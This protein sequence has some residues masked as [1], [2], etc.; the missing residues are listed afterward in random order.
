MGR[1]TPGHNLF[2]CRSGLPPLHGTG[3]HPGEAPCPSA[4]P[5]KPT[6]PAAHR[7]NRLRG[8][9]QHTAGYLILPPRQDGTT[10]PVHPGVCP[11]DRGSRIHRKGGTACTLGTEDGTARGETLLDPLRR[12]RDPHQRRR[13][14][15]DHQKG[16][17][18]IQPA[19]RPLRQ[20]DDPD[21]GR[22]H[23]RVGECRVTADL[24]PR[25][26]TATAAKSTPRAKST[27]R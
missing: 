3:R 6:A 15:T 18:R 4:P 7:R 10:D 8:C 26:S 13:S 14:R 16:G 27:S 23:P 12:L 24:P 19:A 1:E 17:G 2:R 20:A 22:R 5:A 25:H 9:L 21:A 11:G